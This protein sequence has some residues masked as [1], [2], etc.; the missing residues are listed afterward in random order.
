MRNY[1]FLFLTF[2]FALVLHAYPTKTERN[3]SATETSYFD[4]EP[5]ENPL[6]WQKSP[7]S[8]P[9]IFAPRIVSTEHSELAAA[10]SPDLKE[11]YFRKSDEEL[12]NH[13]LVAIQYKDNL[14]T[15][16]FV[17]PKDEISPDGKI[18]YIG[19][20]YRERTRPEANRPSTPNQVSVNAKLLI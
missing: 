2:G 19:N 20:E 10:F 5:P 15:E 13:A 3:S 4:Q 8:I 1:F 12:E 9:E 11:I 18:M 7:G 16:S 14:W 17:V 6:F